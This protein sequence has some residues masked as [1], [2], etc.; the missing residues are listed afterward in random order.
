MVLRKLNAFDQLIPTFSG[1]QMDNRIQASRM[2][3]VK[4]TVETYL[5]TIAS[6]VTDFNTIFKYLKYLQGLDAS[7][8][9]PYVNVTD[10]NTIFN[11]LSI[12]KI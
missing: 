7:V 4:K 1:W 11:S 2:D 6:K 3:Q 9:M 12:Y 8:N 10:L 5:P